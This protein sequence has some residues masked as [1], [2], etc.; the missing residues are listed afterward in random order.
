MVFRRSS[1]SIFKRA[2]PI[3]IA[4]I[5]A[6]P[7]AAQAQDAIVPAPAAMVLENVPPVPASVA[8]QVAKYNEF[9][10]TSFA[11]WHPTKAEMLISRRHKNT[12]QVYRLAKPGGALELLTDYAEPVRSASYEPK[13]GKYYVFGKDT[14][15]NEVFR[16]YRREIAGGEAV[17][18]TPD[19]QRVQ[20]VNWSNGGTQVVYATVPVNRQGS[21][22]KINTTLSIVDPLNPDAPRK[23]AELEGGGWFGFN[24]SPDDKQ[25][26]YVEYISANES[27][28][29]VMDMATAKSRRVTPEN[30]SGSPVSYGGGSFSK[31]GK[32][33]YAVTDLGSEFQRLN[34]IDLA[35]GKHTVLTGDINWD[36]NGVALSD[37]G[38]II[39]F[40]ANEDGN[41][42][43]RLMRTSDHKLMPSPK[44]PLGTIGG[45]SWHKDSTNLALSVTSATSP[46]EVYSVNVKTNEVTRWT[47][48][49]TMQVDAAKFVE[50]DLVRWKSFDNRMISGFVYRAPASKFNGKRPVLINI[51]GGP[52]AQFQPGFL[53]RSNYLTN[54]MGITTIYPNVRGSTGYGKSFLALDNGKL[55]E[56]SVKD[57]GALFD[58]IAAQP[59]KD[60]TRVAVSGGSYGGYM[61][62]AVSTNYAD[63]IAAAIDVVGISNFVTF[64]EKTESYRRDLRR[65]EY[66]DERDPDMRKF[67]ESI[68]P[69]NNAA[70]IKKPLFVVQGKNDPRVPYQ[71]ADQIVATVKKNGT[72]VW[73]M[74]ANDEGHGFGKKINSDYQFYA[75]IGFLE[76]YL[77]SSK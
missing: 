18:I 44:L 1:N 45:V 5:F 20:G 14:G 37:D 71:E 8:A 62:L 21:N 59:D 25:L 19:G 66:G 73:Y 56:D 72:P 30:K 76:K 10:P 77:L 40:V 63:R 12:P 60:A 38:K 69:L 4:A 29:W 3:L 28:L 58:W 55:R 57:I 75:T 34:Y 49:E 9:K 2:L 35:T 15:G 6:A 26:I 41:N 46:S 65:V 13:A 42:V 7:M 64:L 17:P 67:Q 47:T 53:G 24:F 43:L 11:N 32:G 23:L 74:T 51:H 33:V 39:A 52:E 70:K 31:D 36:I 48:H 68:A 61:A 27:H 22:D 54:E 16:G 50:P